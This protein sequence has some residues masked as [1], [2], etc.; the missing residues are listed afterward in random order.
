[1]KQNTP[2]F[3]E[4]VTRFHVT[5]EV[6]HPYKNGVSR[7]CAARKFLVL[8]KQRSNR[9]MHGGEMVNNLVSSVQCVDCF[10]GSGIDREIDRGWHQQK[11]Y[12]GTHVRVLMK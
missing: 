1:M 10:G 9:R 5:D 7:I 8:P 3:E 2:G 11:Y 4:H 12:F 6:L